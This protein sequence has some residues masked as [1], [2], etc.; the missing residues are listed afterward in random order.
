MGMCQKKKKLLNL[1]LFNNISRKDFHLY[2]MKK[3]LET[4]QSCR[5]ILQSQ[6]QNHHSQNFWL[7]T[8]F[9]FTLGPELKNAKGNLTWTNTQTT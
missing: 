2:D 4:R 3:K 5:R 8:P 7:H 9:F 6:L 1:Y